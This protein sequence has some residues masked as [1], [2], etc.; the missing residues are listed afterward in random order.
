MAEAED[1]PIPEGMRKYTM[2]GMTIV[3]PE[4][5]PEEF[6]ASIMEGMV[7]AGALVFDPATSTL[8]ANPAMEQDKIRGMT[9]GMD[10]AGNV[11]PCALLSDDEVKKDLGL[12]SLHVNKED[13]VEKKIGRL[14][15]KPKK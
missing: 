12:S 11:G 14:R 1:Q 5:L 2:L 13:S 4:G 3:G 6:V 7:R 15:G 8:K 9:I 10:D